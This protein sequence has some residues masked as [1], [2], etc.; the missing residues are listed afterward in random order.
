[1]GNFILKAS[2]D[3][4]EDL[5]CIYSTVVDAVTVLGT[6]EEIAQYLVSEG[7]S[8]F[9]A[10]LRL[11]NTDRNGSSCL[12]DTGGTGVWYGWGDEF[13]H[14]SEGPGNGNLPRVHLGEY[15]RLL[16]AHRGTEAAALVVPIEYED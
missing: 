5:Y 13:I 8:D 2:E 6:R 4:T 3:A 12:V 1:M 7:A 14:I 11:A 10:K 9:G 15:L 16:E